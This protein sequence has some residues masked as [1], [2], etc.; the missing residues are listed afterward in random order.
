MNPATEKG[1]LLSVRGVLKIDSIVIHGK[2]FSTF[3]DAFVALK[4]MYKSVELFEITYLETSNC[5][6]K[7][8]VIDSHSLETFKET[9]KV[10]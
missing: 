8:H 9:M 2:D 4:N 10:H 1:S 5:S 6:E 7:T 3:K